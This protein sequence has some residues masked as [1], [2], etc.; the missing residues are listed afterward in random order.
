MST[1]SARTREDLC[2]GVLRPWPAEDGL[3]VRLRLVGGLLSG[4]QLDSLLSVSE[5]FGDG[6]V[7]LTGR[8]NLQ[9]RGLAGASCLSRDA[10]EAFESTGLL[11]SKEHE[12]VRNL[13][14]SPQ[15]GY[16]GGC[17]DLRPVAADL[18]HFLRADPALAA[19]PGRFLF[20]LDDG[21]G[22]LLDTR[23]DLGLVA[24]PGDRCQLRIGDGWGAVVPL[25]DAP[26]AL[27]DLA[28]SFL[29]VRGSGPQ[30]PWHVR[31]LTGAARDAMCRTSGLGV[32]EVGSRHGEG[33]V[34]AVGPL[35]YG[36]VDGGVHVAVPD[37]I[38]TRTEARPFLT[39][40]TLIVTPWR[41]IFV[42]SNDALYLKET[43]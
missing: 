25:T 30:A 12:L 11:P 22:D 5:R 6:M 43:S 4:A 16:A 17:A 7:H 9:V 37:G 15:S 23:A 19:L 29:T 39:E 33:R 38:L 14:V 21:R 26:S 10:I 27:V 32:P 13:L 8:A 3:L 41:G 42:P 31:E 35:A 1:S 28:R 2:P 36:P 20:V 18:D 24:L 34:S 40:P